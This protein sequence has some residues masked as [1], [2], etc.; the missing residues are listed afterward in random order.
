[1]KIG[2]L[3]NPIAGMGG[4]V[5]LRGTDDNAFL[6]AF[7]RGAR[8]VAPMIARRF[9][10]CLRSLCSTLVLERARFFAAP[11]IMGFDYFIDVGL[12]AREVDVKVSY[13]TTRDDTIKSVETMIREGIDVIVFV[14]GDGTARDIA[15]IA[16]PSQIP[17]LGVPAGVKMFS[18][19]FAVSPEA[20][21][22]IV[23]KC[24]EERCTEIEAEVLDLD[25]DSYRRDHLSVRLYAIVKTLGLPNL[26]APRKDVTVG[27]EEA[28]KGIAR[29]F[30]EELMKPNVLYI[31][32]PGSTVKAIADE[33]GIEKTLLGFDAVVNGKLVARDLW[34]RKMLEIVK[35]FKERKLVLTP[36]GGQGFLIGRGNKQLTP[37]ILRY[38]DKEDLI[39]VATPSKVAK[40]RYLIVDTGDP[41]LDSRYRSY[42]RVI[43]GYRE[44]IVMKIIAARDLIELV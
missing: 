30:V 31:L 43:V 32:G 42:H 40:L 33:L 5:G 16:A 24:L 12:P 18:A 26:L 25:E 11:H 6:E 14:G 21:A 38:F 41:E 19:V 44:E 23:C 34:G 7:R 20:A 8:P 2:F 15:S 4:A 17:I 22:A 3:I 29:Y 35:S 36:I 1:M 27:D 13:P 10:N 39:I 28:K 9:L 37:E